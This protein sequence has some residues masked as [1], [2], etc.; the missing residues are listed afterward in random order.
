MKVTQL[1]IQEAIE[2]SSSMREAASKL[3]INFK[4]F[5]TYAN[6][7]GLYKPNPSGKGTNKP[8]SNKTP[9]LEILAGK[10]PSYNTHRLKIRLFSEMGWKHQCAACSNTTWCS[11]PIPLELDHIDGNPYNHK[12]SNLRLLCPNCHAQTPTYRNKIRQQCPSQSAPLQQKEYVEGQAVA[13][14]HTQQACA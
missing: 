1:E 13:S 11:H 14:A 10:H 6:K 3:P 12:V 5:R 9:L 8:R 4:T 7:L 2:H